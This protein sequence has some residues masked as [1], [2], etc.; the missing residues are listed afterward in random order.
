MRAVVPGYMGTRDAS[1]RRQIAFQV[2]RREVSEPCGGVTFDQRI[3]VRTDMAGE[4]ANKGSCTRRAKARGTGLD[5]RLVELR[6]A[7]RRGAG[8]RA[9]GK[10]MQEGDAALFHQPQG[11]LEVRIGFCR[12]TG[13]QVCAKG[14]VRAI[15]S[16]REWR[17]FMR[18][19][20]RSSPCC[21]DKCM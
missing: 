18:F 8:A 2:Y 14:G 15:A 6:H 16:A 5:D 12:E 20:I 9:V 10:G 13:D 17:R 1:S 7:G 19:R 11:I 3:S 21:K 4:M